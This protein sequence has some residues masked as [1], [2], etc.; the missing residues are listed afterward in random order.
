[1]VRFALAEESEQSLVRSCDILRDILGAGDTGD[2]GTKDWLVEQLA[3]IGANIE[4]DILDFSQEFENNK[5]KKLL[6]LLKVF[7]VTNKK[8][9]SFDIDKFGEDNFQQFAQKK[10]DQIIDILDGMSY[11]THMYNI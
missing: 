11:Q 3:K 7:K 8:L 1:M 6:A 10:L 4:T 5:L 2:L 9:T